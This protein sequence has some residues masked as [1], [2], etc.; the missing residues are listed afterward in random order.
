MKVNFLRFP[1]RADR[2]SGLLAPNEQDYS[3]FD[4][5][6]LKTLKG[7]SHWRAGTRKSMESNSKMAPKRRR[8]PNVQG[9]IDFEE[10]QLLGDV[11]R[12]TNDGSV[13]ALAAV[14]RNASGHMELLLPENIDYATMSIRTLAHKCNI[15]VKVLF[16]L[17]VDGNVDPFDPSGGVN[18]EQLYIED[19]DVPA[20]N[21]GVSP[22]NNRRAPQ[23]GTINDENEEVDAGLGDFDNDA[24]SVATLNTFME[25]RSRDFDEMDSAFWPLRLEFSVLFFSQVLD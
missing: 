18:Y 1:K 13:L 9:P 3:Y 6:K 25:D 24:A 16:R 17:E 19:E 8:A 21:A 12:P 11:F 5:R 15:V 10:Q 20:S 14:D 4:A 22:A 7:P 23:E 2:L